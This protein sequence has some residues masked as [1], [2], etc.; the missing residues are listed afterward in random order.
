MKRTFCRAVCLAAALFL[1][2]CDEDPAS[3]TASPAAQ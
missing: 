2:G 1:M 3:T